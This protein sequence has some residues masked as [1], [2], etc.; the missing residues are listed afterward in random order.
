MDS[1]LKHW[2]EKLIFRDFIPLKAGKNGS[3]T[4][5]SPEKITHVREG[6]RGKEKREGTS[7]AILLQLEE[8]KKKE[9]EEEVWRGKK[10]EKEKKKW[11]KWWMMMES[12]S[13]GRKEKKNE[14]N[15]VYL[16][17]YYFGAIF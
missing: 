14:R 8:E 10:E 9:K 3:G 4:G 17:L 1:N 12:A 2:G 5:K 6:R 16:A 7:I 11:E 15:L 13:V